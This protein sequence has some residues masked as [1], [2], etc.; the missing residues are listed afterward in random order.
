MGQPRE[1]RTQRFSFVI[2]D[3]AP[4]DWTMLADLPEL[5]RQRID[6]TLNDVNASYVSAFG[7]DAAMIDAEYRD[8]TWRG[9]I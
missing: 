7:E 6:D 2:K 8:G 1:A 5:D 4:I 3:K 9:A